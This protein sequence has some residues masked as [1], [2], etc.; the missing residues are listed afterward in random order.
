MVTP[1]LCMA[2]MLSRTGRCMSRWREISRST[3][4]LSRSP[5]MPVVATASWVCIAAAT[6]SGSWSNRLELWIDGKYQIQLN[7]LTDWTN[8]T[9][10]INPGAH[11]IEWRYNKTSVFVDNEDC[12]WVDKITVTGV[13]K[14]IA[15]EAWALYR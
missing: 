5:L 11:V 1:R 4:R 13:P 8:Q 6:M 15:D 10:Y 14:A 3:P 9:Y 12:G 2:R 7:G